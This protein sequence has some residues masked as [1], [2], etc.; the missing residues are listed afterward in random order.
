MTASMFHVTNL[1][2]AGASAT[3]F[4]G[5]LTATVTYRVAAGG[6]GDGAGK[7]RKHDARLVTTM[8][9]VCDK[10]CPVNL[11][12]HS[13]FNLQGHDCARSVGGCTSWNPVATRRAIA[14]ES[15]WFQPLNP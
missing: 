3:L 6:G 2:P 14:L 13:Y 9:A 15:A 12:Q 4:P 7:Q 10:M 8:T 1:T 11:A 5:T